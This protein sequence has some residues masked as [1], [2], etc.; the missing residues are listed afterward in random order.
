MKKLLTPLLTIAII[1]AIAFAS[2]I[3]AQDSYKHP[4]LNSSGQ[5]FDSNG[6]KLGWVTADGDVYNAKGEKI[7][8]IKNQELLDPKGKKLGTLGKNGTFYDP[9]G[10][11]E[12]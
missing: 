11:V 3:F 6:T 7:A 12:F 5:V 4:H 2:P 10:A 9:K 1:T 8:T